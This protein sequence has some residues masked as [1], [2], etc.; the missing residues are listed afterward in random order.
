MVGKTKDEWKD[1][2]IKRKIQMQDTNSEK[3]A[4]VNEWDDETS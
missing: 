4:K 1:K 2:M 3:D